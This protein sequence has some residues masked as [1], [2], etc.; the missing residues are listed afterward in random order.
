MARKTRAA[1]PTS[2]ADFMGDGGDKETLDKLAAAAAAEN[3]KAGVGHNGGDPTD[4][5]IQRNAA[6]IELALVEIDAA[7]RIMQKARAALSAAE[8]TAKTDCGSKQ[9]ASAIKAA[10]QLKRSADK[11]GQ[12]SIVTEHR[13][14]G[15]VLKA[16]NVPLYHQF[17]LFN[18]ADEPAPL[19]PSRPV[20]TATAYAQGEQSFAD[21]VAADGNPFTPGSETFAAW[22]NGWADR[23]RAAL[24]GLGLKPGDGG[25]SNGVTD[26]PTSH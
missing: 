5:I 3:A 22:A 2:H 9:W 24:E 11:G 8:K 17:G 10:V 23:Q 13:Q 25:T 16:M 1:Q 12:G 7:G 20:T 4:E 18:V 6:A 19:D 15:V 14:M 26:E 21:E